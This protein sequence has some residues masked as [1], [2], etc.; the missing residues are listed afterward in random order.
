MNI[1]MPFYEFDNQT[2]QKGQNAMER[3]IS[4]M[5]EREL[6]AAQSLCDWR[7]EALDIE[8]LL[9]AERSAQKTTQ[10]VYN[11]EPPHRVPVFASNNNTN[12]AT[13]QRERPNALH[14][15]PAVKQEPFEMNGQ[16]SPH[17]QAAG[18]VFNYQGQ[19]HQGPVSP[20]SPYSQGMHSPASSCSAISPVS[21][22]G[23]ISPH[24]HHSGSVSPVS[25]PSP[26][27]YYGAMGAAVFG[28]YAAASP[29]Y[30]SNYPS[31]EM[32]SLKRSAS[33]MEKNSELYRAKRER[34]NIAVRRSREKKKQ[35]E[36]E[37]EQRVS[38]LSEE[39]SDLQSRLDIV[40]KEL[41]LLKS[42]YKTIGIALPHDARCKIEA[43]IAKLTN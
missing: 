5:D 14:L 9:A 37:N 2:T 19:Q 1:D 30:F 21:Q 40:L 12:S 39:N 28:R 25:R 7:E 35:R 17:Y 27:P 8:E 41:S 18:S 31:C 24:S 20:H 22:R 15:N 6:S 38:R 23:P 33:A 32:N 11:S 4:G 16:V 3:A 36:T 34:N 13:G 10:S 29:D 43:E 42:L 26:I